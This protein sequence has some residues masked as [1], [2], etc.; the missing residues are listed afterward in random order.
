MQKISLDKLVSGLFSK[1]EI[2]SIEYFYRFI[3]KKKVV[4]FVPPIH[5]EE[6]ALEMSKA[7]AGVIGNYEMCSFRIE[8][9]GTFRPTGK[10][11]PFSGK[12]NKLSYEKELELGMECSPDR[13]NYVIDALLK[14]HPY[15][16]TAY[17]IYDFKRREKKPAGLA[18]TLRTKQT[19][20]RLLTKLNQGNKESAV[21]ECEFKKIAIT[22]LMVDK[23]II[24][25]SREIKC[26]GILNISKNNFKFIQI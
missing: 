13:L 24:E 26:D 12:R 5:V 18:V 2:L 14:N 19:L 10:A 11:K 23:Y 1:R 9:T 20:K 21:T 7:G 3:D 25:A 8:G 4:V 6:L 17:E 16:E 15:E 22:N